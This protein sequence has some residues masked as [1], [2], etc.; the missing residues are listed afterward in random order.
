MQYKPVHSLGG[1]EGKSVVWLILTPR[2]RDTLIYPRTCHGQHL[3]PPG[4]LRECPPARA[5]CGSTM[6]LSV[7]PHDGIDRALSHFELT[8]SLPLRAAFTR[9]SDSR[10]QKRQLPNTIKFTTN[11][12]YQSAYEM[13][14]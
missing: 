3:T 14:I 8:N 12:V 5:V 13:D 9:T 1:R 6:D 10:R 4:R 7:R 2:I 11:H